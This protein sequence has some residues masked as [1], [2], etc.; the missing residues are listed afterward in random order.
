ML[1]Y[2]SN[3]AHPFC[4][5]KLP[6]KPNGPNP[7]PTTFGERV[8]VESVAIKAEEIPIS[9]IEVMQEIGIKI[10]A[11]PA[12]PLSSVDLKS[13]DLV[14][15]LSHLKIPAKARKNYLHWV[16]PESDF[17]ASSS[18]GI[19]QRHRFRDVKASIHRQLQLLSPRLESR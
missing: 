2:T 13:F 1:C 16:I 17:E 3:R 19:E 14:I 7:R 10:N 4:L 12:K 11:Q 8:S 9:L 18:S 15:S 5:P 6:A